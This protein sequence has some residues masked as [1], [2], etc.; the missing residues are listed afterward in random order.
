M[1]LRFLWEFTTLK[2]KQVPEVSNNSWKLKVTL[3]QKEETVK[4]EADGDFSEGEEV[5][6]AQA[7]KVDINIRM[8]EEAEEECDSDKFYVEFLRKPINKEEDAD[9]L[10]SDALY[11]QFVRDVTKGCRMF[12]QKED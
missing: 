4:Y 12:G 6:P 2:F 11:N 5:I 10:G 1:L 9:N 3:D 8:V 7:I